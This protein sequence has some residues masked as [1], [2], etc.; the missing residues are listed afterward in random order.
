M[1]N[2]ISRRKFLLTSAAAATVAGTD[3]VAANVF[4]TSAF[5]W[6]GPDDIDIMC[7]TVIEHFPEVS[8]QMPGVRA[9]AQRLLESATLQ[10]ADC[11]YVR[12]AL[13]KKPGISD[14]FKAY[15]IQEFVVHT[16]FYDF[17]AGHDA[18]LQVL[19][20]DDASPANV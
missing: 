17:V 9:F 10:T 5:D 3:A 12:S 16:N 6:F 11:T 15:L 13:A 4:A 20:A 1:P 7:K 2:T 14:D 19:A 18:H 8:T